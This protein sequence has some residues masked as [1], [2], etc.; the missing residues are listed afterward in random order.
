MIILARSFLVIVP[1]VVVEV[2]V[3]GR[4]NR[5]CNNKAGVH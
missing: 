4:V 1:E 2:G 3:E 5:S